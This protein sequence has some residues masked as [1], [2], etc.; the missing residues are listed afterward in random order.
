MR[1]ITC[2]FLRIT[3]QLESGRF[4]E[5]RCTWTTLDCGHSDLIHN[6]WRILDKKKSNLDLIKTM[7]YFNAVFGIKTHQSP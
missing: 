1:F 3:A 4:E 2:I 5:M 6:I 7:A